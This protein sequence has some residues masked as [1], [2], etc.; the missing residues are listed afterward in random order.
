MIETHAAPNAPSRTEREAMLAS[1][2]KLIKAEVKRAK[3]PKR[4]QEDVEQ[5]CNLAL[6][7]LT[8]RFDPTR[9]TKWSTYAVGCLRNVL[10]S[11]M[12]QNRCEDQGAVV[13]IGG[14]RAFDDLWRDAEPD[15]RTADEP[16]GAEDGADSDTVGALA[17]AVR[18][19]LAAGILDQLGSGWRRLVERVAFDG[20]TADQ[21]AEQ[22]GVPVKVVRCN[23]KNALRHLCKLGLTRHVVSD[24]E[25]A[26]ATAPQVPIDRQ[27]ANA[28][29]RKQ[30]AARQNAAVVSELEAAANADD[31][32]V[33]LDRLDDDM[34]VI[35]C[36]LIDRS[37]TVDEAVELLGGNRRVIVGQLKNVVKV[38]QR[39][40]E[41]S[42]PVD[43]VE[44]LTW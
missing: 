25:V 26:T 5:E 21:I 1:V 8:E 23:L 42:T 3:I 33:E 38:I 2:Q 9:G 11:W 13:C 14:A 28:T 35:V 19:K 29:V 43:R 39:R 10:K 20:L 27:K 6:W 7:P 17:N 40:A 16:L 12:A 44:V 30:A 15:P 18:R 36:A 4:H 22:D 32:T 41:N 37:F 34:R 24:Q 31:F